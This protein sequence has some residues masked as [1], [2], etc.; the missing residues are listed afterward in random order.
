MQAR[1]EDMVRGERDGL[2]DRAG[3]D[4]YGPGDDSPR[5]PVETH[6]CLRETLDSFEPHKKKGTE[7]RVLPA[8][9]VRLDG[10]DASGEL[11]DGR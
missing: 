8:A 5:K 6:A 7:T 1:S 4:S 11:Q 9:S 2:K 3:G 10:E